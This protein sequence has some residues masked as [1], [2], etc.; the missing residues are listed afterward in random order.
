M[1]FG[2]THQTVSPSLPSFF[3]SMQSPMLSLLSFVVIVWK[4]PVTSES[5]VSAVD[6]T[7]HQ[8]L[9]VH[10]ASPDSHI[11]LT[12]RDVG[13]LVVWPHPKKKKIIKIIISFQSFSDIC[14]R[15]DS[16]HNITSL[17]LYIFCNIKPLLFLQIHKKRPL[18][19]SL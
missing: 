13:R 1:F 7:K 2:Y 18:Q 6:N 3:Y 15:K 4:S 11:M 10:K 14:I 12:V 19:I 5:W 17:V 8:L 16:R 9:Q